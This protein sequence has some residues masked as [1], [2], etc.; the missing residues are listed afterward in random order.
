LLNKNRYK[1]D[2][3]NKSTYK[4]HV[5]TILLI[6][7]SAS[8]FAFSY[9]VDSYTTSAYSLTSNPSST[10]SL[11]G[12]NYQNNSS[13]N[14]VTATSTPIKHLIVLF[15]ENVAFDHYFGTYPYAINPLGEPSFI[16]YPNTPSV[17]NLLSAGLISNNTNLVDPFRL[18]RKVSV[19]ND[20]NHSYTAE[21]QAYNGGLLDK[22][23]EYTGAYAPNF[24]C[25]SENRKDCHP[26]TV[27][28]YYDGNTVTAL[29]NYAQRF[30]MSDNY[31]QTNFGESTPGHINLISGQTHGVIPENIKGIVV[32]GTL[33]GDADPVSD[34]CSLTKQDVYLFPKLG[35]TTFPDATA[36]I[37]MTGKNVGDLLNAKNITWGW[38]SAG[39]APTPNNSTVKN[40][41][42][43]RHD[44]GYGVISYDY[45]SS[46]EPFQFYNTTSNPNHLPPFS[47]STIGYSDQANHQYDLSNFWAASKSGNLPSVSFIKAPSYQQGHAGYSG[48]LLD[49]TFVVNT[50]NKIQKLPQWNQTAIILTYDDSDGWYDHVMPPIISQSNDPVYDKLLG[51]DNLCGTPKNASYND[52]CGYGPRLPLLI[53]SPFSRVNYI[54]HQITDQTSILKFI[55]DNWHLG[56]LGG[57]S[58]DEKAGSILGMFEFTKGHNNQK[59]F[60]D[61]TT[62]TRISP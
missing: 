17:N 2:K 54:D 31:Y 49:Q 11:Y 36:K 39:F 9:L 57:Q 1:E 60:L 35:N 34:V 62:G 33:I 25:F 43:D 8:L 42:G 56:R 44:N 24:L 19:T 46:V 50:I 32:N 59:L 41:G 10:S 58:M 23:V 15:Q 20:N 22:F 28:G 47:N 26:E 18:D 48:P 5:F 14:L 40:C 16:A 53:I 55:E 3:K 37:Q 38:F 12:I 29:W 45:F 27:M 6:V 30:A 21:Q 52:R 4:I 13:N 61:P 7:A 51:K